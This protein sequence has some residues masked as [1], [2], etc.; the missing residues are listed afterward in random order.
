MALGTDHHD[1]L[2]IGLG[3]LNVVHSVLRLSPREKVEGS[4][5]G[6]PRQGNGQGDAAV[7]QVDL[8]VA[9]QRLLEL[10]ELVVGDD[11]LVDR[12]FAA[13]DAQKVQGLGG[14]GAV[15]HGGVED[16]HLQS[17]IQLLELFDVGTAGDG[18]QPI[19]VLHSVGSSFTICR[20]VGIR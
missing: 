13:G 10:V 6:D 7:G 19:H 3:I 14:G 18:D 20:R 12:L 17:L 5:G 8:E 15:G 9:L 16:R 1:Q 11:G 4:F 2:G